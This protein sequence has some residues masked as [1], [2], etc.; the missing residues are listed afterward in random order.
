MYQPNLSFKKN[1][2]ELVAPSPVKFSLGR[3][4][5]ALITGGSRGFGWELAL[6]LASKNVNVIIADIMSPPCFQ[7]PQKNIAYYKCNVA[8]NRS[9][10]DLRAWIKE[11]Y[12]NVNILFNN[13][14]VVYISSLEDST[15]R[16]IKNVIDVNYIGAFMMIE[17]FL[18]DMIE[19]QN[20]YIVNIASVLGMV[21]PARIASYGASKAGLIAY[22]D[23]LCQRL[24]KNKTSG[25]RALL[26]C[27]GKLK[28]E[29]FARVKTP[30]K[31]L[32]PDV[33][34]KKLA[35]QIMVAI[36][37]NS[38][39]S[40]NSPYY[41]NLMPII[42]NLSWPYLRILKTLSGMDRSTAIPAK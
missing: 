18:P 19:N 12:G 38:T 13:A 25:V 34:P 41:V 15:D 3:N 31:F 8:S 27:P 2:E 21:S 32:A 26:V 6:Q 30:S 37:R 39:R 4:T 1:L 10:R 35:L 28:T 17:T 22:H 11:R 16:D 29:M 5:I 14:G 9:I 23:S 33:D 40:L 7:H 24:K 42:K 20:G 36:S